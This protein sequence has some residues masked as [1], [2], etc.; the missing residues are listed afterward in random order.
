MPCCVIRWLDADFL[1]YSMLTDTKHIHDLIRAPS[2]SLWN[3][4]WRWSGLSL[5][6]ADVG[7]GFLI[8]GVIVRRTRALASWSLSVPLVLVSVMPCLHRLWLVCQIPF[9]IMT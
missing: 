7:L 3:K 2:H 8:G 5:L 1:L 9:Q 4:G 6:Y